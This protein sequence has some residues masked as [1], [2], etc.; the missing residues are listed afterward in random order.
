[1]K[2]YKVKISDAALLDIQ[3]ATDW[4]NERLPKLGSRF[5]KNVRQQINTLKNSA[6][7]HSIRYSN[8]RCT[9][10]NKFPFLIHFIID[11]ENQVLEIFAIIHT[12]RN[13]KIWEQRTKNV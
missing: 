8:V 7:G 10:V 2:S 12:S 6:D 13:P 11:E 1:M 5:Q 9:L 3:E 4:Y